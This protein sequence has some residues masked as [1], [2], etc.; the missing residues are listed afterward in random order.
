MVMQRDLLRW[1]STPATAHPSHL[2]AITA[3]DTHA[4]APRP[5]I[6]T[7]QPVE[8]RA[9]DGGLRFGEME[10]DCIISHGAAAFLKERLFDQSDAYRV[11]V[12]ERSG[13][14]AVANLKKNQYYSTIHKNDSSVVQV[15]PRG[16]GQGCMQG[17]VPWVSASLCVATCVVH[18]IDALLHCCGCAA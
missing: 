9:R 16:Q 13:L 2:L 11:H 1:L 3:A 17:F 14:I 18:A 4:L 6:L 10:R 15:G 12:C 7:R 8:G 5:Q